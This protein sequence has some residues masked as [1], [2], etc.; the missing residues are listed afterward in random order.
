MST[1]VRIDGQPIDLA[2]EV[3]LPLTLINPHLTYGSIPDS[4]VTIPNAPFSLRNQ[5]IFEYAE[6][7]QAGNDLRRYTCESFYNGALIY[8]G[9]AYVK[10]A[11]PLAGYQLEASDDLRRFFGE[12]QAILLPDLDLGTVDLPGGDPSVLEPL[13]QIEGKPAACF[14]VI[15]NPDYYSTNGGLVDYNGVVNDYEAGD[16]TD[17]GP[18]VPML[19]VSF[20]LSRIAELTGVT[21]E[22]PF[23]EH[24]TWSKLILTNWRALDGAEEITV[25]RHVPAWTIPQFLLELRKVPNLKLDFYPTDSRLVL[26]FWEPCLKSAAKWDWTDK[27]APGHKKYPEVNRRL[28]LSFNLDGGDGLMKD[29]PAAME[30]YITPAADVLGDVALGLAKI[31]LG[32]TTFLLDDETGLP[33]A[34]QTGVTELFN[35]LAVSTAPRL[36]FWHGIDEDG[37]PVAYP[38]A[39]GISLYLN[40]PTGIAATSWKQTE[41]MRLGMFY[42]KK[43]FILD[44]TDLALFSF[45]DVVHYNGLNYLVASITGELPVV[46]AVT[47]LLLKV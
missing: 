32:L 11:D 38:E 47:V 3:S 41:S 35:Q 21:I 46:K 43:D 15:I 4:K 7:P 42:L 26:D 45:G 16:Y 8:K 25:N 9:M 44:E 2:E 24:P 14:P 17:A 30:D 1:E 28:H 40:G 10:D 22:G 33:I 5:Q 12:Y 13:I 39:D 23:L 31:D 27:A 18:K 6:M 36:L 29:R 19:F 34:R 20:L 37:V